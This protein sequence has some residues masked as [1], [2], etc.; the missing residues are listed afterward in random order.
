MAIYVYDPGLDFAKGTNKQIATKGFIPSRT[1]IGVGTDGFIRPV[2]QE[3]NLIFSGN[4]LVSIRSDYIAKG[5][6]VLDGAG[7]PVSAT[8]DSQNLYTYPGIGTL[9]LDGSAPVTFNR[10][11]GTIEYVYVPSQTDPITFSGDANDIEIIMNYVS[12]G[13]GIIFDGESTVNITQNY[14]PEG[15]IVFDGDAGTFFKKGDISG[16]GVLHKPRTRQPVVYQ[17]E[18]SLYRKDAWSVKF[19]KS[20]TTSEYI[21]GKKYKFITNLP[22][23]TAPKDTSKSFIRSLPKKTPVI[24]DYVAEPTSPKTIQVLPSASKVDYYNHN[25]FLIQQDD[26]LITEMILDDSLP[27]I[28]VTYDSKVNSIR[29][30]DEYIIENFL[31]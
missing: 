31:V 28:A 24:F 16:R 14:A 11:S 6:L 26:E 13:T 19:F 20:A 18:P 7:S 10:A 30:D 29:K 21:E 25:N 4:A 8:V 2:F 12:V 17:H 1:N 23:Y 22:K 5:E 27:L 15:G 9:N 3:T